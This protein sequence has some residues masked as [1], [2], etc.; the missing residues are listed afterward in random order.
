VSPTLNPA[1]LRV[2]D[3]VELSVAEPVTVNDETVIS[4]DEVANAVVS[5]QRSGLTKNEA[6]KVEINLRSVNLV[7][8]KQVPLRIKREAQPGLASESVTSSGAGQD[9]AIASG[10]E[11]TAYVNGT[12]TLDLSRLRSA[13]Q[14][15][16]EIRITSTPPTAEVSIDG[17]TMGAAPYTAH[18]RPG[19]HDIVVR[20]A[21]YAPYHKAV[22]VADH[23]AD[24]R[25]ELQR[26]DNTEA[27]PQQKAAATSLADL[28]RQARARKAAQESQKSSDPAGANSATPASPSQN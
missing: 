1:A 26:Q 14:P 25:V 7:D 4:T 17:R 20:A 12:L 23:P 6:S 15:T 11:I 2:G 18:V 10:S 19:E 27:M 21:G 5:S 8:G 13:S 22:L 16:T 9:V 28:A 24:L 3:A